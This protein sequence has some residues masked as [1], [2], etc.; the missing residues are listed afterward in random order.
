MYANM[1]VCYAEISRGRDLG[2]LRHTMLPEALSGALHDQKTAI[3]K[4]EGNQI[5]T[6]VLVSKGKSSFCTE[7]QRANRRI[8][9]Q[10]L[11]VI[12]VPRHPFTAIMVQVAKAR[13]ESAA[14]SVLDHVFEGSQLLRPSQCDLR[15]S[16]VGIGVTGITV[17]SNL[18]SGNY[19]LAANDSLIVSPR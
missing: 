1:S 4:V 6:P 11:F 2:G 16:R 9:A 17:P 19:V 13:I 5:L 14:G 10:R 7:A 8:S 15:R 12:T 18:A 3:L